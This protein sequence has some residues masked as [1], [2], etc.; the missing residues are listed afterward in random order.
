MLGDD[1][2]SVFFDVDEFAT[3]FHKVVDELPVEPGFQ[4]IKSAVDEEELQRFVAGTVEAL[5]FPT[6]A[7][8]LL[9]GDVITDG[10]NTWRVLREAFLVNDG[11]ESL[12]YLTPA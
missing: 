9:E 10:T 6:A 3:T 12:C 7:A 1:D 2:L 4:G 8:Q 5:R 11:A